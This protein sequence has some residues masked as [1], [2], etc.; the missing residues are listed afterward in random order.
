[1]IISDPSF[2]GIKLLDVA[3]FILWSI[4][5]IQIGRLYGWYEERRTHSEH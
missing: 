1:M 3:I 5:M 2:L 4:I